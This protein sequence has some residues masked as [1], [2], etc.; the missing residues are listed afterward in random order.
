MPLELQA[1]AVQSYA[2]ILK[3]SFSNTKSSKN[4]S[5]VTFQVSVL[6]LLGIKME[7]LLKKR[8]KF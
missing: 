5:Q 6:L 4:T 3:K 7:M 2:Y 8:Q 1:L